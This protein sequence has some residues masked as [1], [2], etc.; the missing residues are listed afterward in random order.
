MCMPGILQYLIMSPPPRELGQ[1]NPNISP[2]SAWDNYPTYVI[3]I[4][5]TYILLL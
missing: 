4:V 1:L 5:L 2:K 3:A